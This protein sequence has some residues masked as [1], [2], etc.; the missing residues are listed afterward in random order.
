MVIISKY[1]FGRR[2]GMKFHVQSQEIRSCPICGNKLS[3]IGTRKRGI[4]NN[5]ATIIT[6]VIR[7]LR[8]KYCRAIHHELPDKI[9]PYK[10]RCAETV[11]KIIEGDTAG[12]SCENSTIRRIK[13][14][15]LAHRLYFEGVLTSLSEK[16]GAVFSERPAPKEIVRAVVN[17]NLWIHTRSAF[18][19]G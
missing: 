19:P 9:I 5:E 7:R 6:L 13:A 8:C 14:W 11:E 16:F 10:R 17:A 4:V 12:I 18:S 2:R 15:W 3:V 1:R